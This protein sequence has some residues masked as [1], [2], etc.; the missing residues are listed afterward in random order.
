MISAS[1]S[2]TVAIRNVDGL[3]HDMDEISSSV[4][5][6]VALATLDLLPSS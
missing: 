3:D 2:G 5:Q 6:D 1:T 4:G